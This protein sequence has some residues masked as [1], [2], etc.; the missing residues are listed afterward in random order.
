MYAVSGRQQR[1]I[2]SEVDGR[3]GVHFGLN[4]KNMCVEL[5]ALRYDRVIARSSK[6]FIDDYAW[7]H[8]FRTH[9]ALLRCTRCMCSFHNGSG[10]PTTSRDGG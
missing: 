3:A 10:E 6:A 4:A 7:K 9:R 1:V 5:R 2:F 8:H